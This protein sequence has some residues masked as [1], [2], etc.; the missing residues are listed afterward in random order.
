MDALTRILTAVSNACPASPLILNTKLPYTVCIKPIG[1]KDCGVSWL[2]VFFLYLFPTSSP[3]PLPPAGVSG[4]ASGPS[5][6]PSAHRD[7]PPSLRTS[8]SFPVERWASGV[9]AKMPLGM[10]A[11]HT[12]VP[13]FEFQLFLIL[14]SH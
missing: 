3:H 8:P 9:V 2:P 10:P 5:T 12:T 14:N 13:G 7:L 1:S 4:L 11:S 6:A